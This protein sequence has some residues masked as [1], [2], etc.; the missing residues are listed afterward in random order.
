MSFHNFH[1]FSLGGAS[2]HFWILGKQEV[3]LRVRNAFDN[4]RDNEEKTPEEDKDFVAEI[5]DKGAT[6][7]IIFEAG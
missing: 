6:E 2:V 7:V 1:R 4:A 5:S 3:H